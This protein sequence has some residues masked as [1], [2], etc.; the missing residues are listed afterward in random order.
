YEDYNGKYFATAIDST[1]TGQRIPNTQFG[2]LSDPIE[3]SN[4]TKFLQ[5]LDKNLDNQQPTSDKNI[6][7]K[8]E[9]ILINFRIQFD[10]NEP[11]LDKINRILKVSESLNDFIKL[12]KN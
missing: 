5:Y 10:K 6:V 7:N 11:L 9:Q 3:T 4:F 12:I 2:V 8:V 1:E